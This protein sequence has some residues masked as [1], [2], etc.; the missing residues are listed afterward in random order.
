M[1]LAIKKKCIIKY[2]WVKALP[3]P[4]F[5]SDDVSK[6]DKATCTAADKGI[7]YSLYFEL[8]TACNFAK[9]SANTSLINNL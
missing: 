6:W 1:Y 5:A 2:T 4:A 7:P 3:Y 9:V 8:Y